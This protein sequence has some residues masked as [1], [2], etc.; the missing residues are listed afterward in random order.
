MRQLLFCLLL[1][2]SL[3]A[4]T[5]YLVKDINTTL[6]LDVKSSAPAQFT[7]YGGKVYFVATTDAAGAE[8]WSTDDTSSGT[9]MVADILP[10]VPSS[11]SRW[12]Q[13]VNNA[14]LF[15][16][17]DVN[18]GVE[19]W[20]TDGSAAGTRM[21]LDI[22]PG[23][24][25]SDPGMNIVDRNRLLFAADTVTN[26]RELWI[27]DGTA[28]GTRMLKDLAPGSGSSHPRHFVAFGNSVYFI[29]GSGI[30][31]TN[32]TEAGTVKVATVSARNLAVAGSQLFFE[33]YTTDANWELWV[34]DGTEAGTRMLPEIR[35]GNQAAFANDFSLQGFTPFGNRVL[36]VASDGVH[37][38]EL[39]IS[40]G[41]AAGTHM[42]RD[43]TPGEMGT[44][45]N[46][47]H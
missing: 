44:W 36:F 4:Q 3:R 12:F 17:R 45:E 5:P 25:S 20:V 40:D 2:L 30:W 11:N 47:F 19:L 32:G 37:G 33:G 31:K 8:L 42:V 7:A 35:P 21:L 14:L 18:H 39:W 46:R 6:S 23:P 13:V 41:S 34:S 9:A 24:N 1:S 16:S 28:A 22:N 38:R 26:G 27:S 29:T 10:G 43:F 15:Q